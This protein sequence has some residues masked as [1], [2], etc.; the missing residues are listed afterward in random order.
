[1]LALVHGAL[2]ASCGVLLRRRL[3]TLV[4]A[5]LSH[6]LVDAIKHEEAVD[7]H[8]GLQLDVLTLDALLLG[9]A[10]LLINTRRGAFSPESLGAVAGC[11]LDGEHLL[12]KRARGPVLH[13]LF[14]HGRWPSRSIG[15]RSQ[16]AI[17]A[18]AWL[19]VLM[20]TRQR[21]MA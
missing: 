15:V 14:P 6:L 21:E 1:M 3:P 20:R 18:V 8:G 11:L 17:G 4:V 9:L 16:F 2:G 19:A 13:R 7:E 10:F 5:V 12:R